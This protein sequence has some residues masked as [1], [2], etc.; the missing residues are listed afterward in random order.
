M[1]LLKA[2]AQLSLLL[3]TFLLPWQP[4]YSQAAFPQPNWDRALAVESAQSINSDHVLKSLYQSARAGDSRQVL[5][6]LFAIEQNDKWPVPARE[7]TIWS[8]AINLADLD[9]NTVSLEVLD[10]LSAY[11]PRTLVAHDDRDSV[12]VPLF[13][14]SSAGAGVRN[15]WAR[16]QSGGRAEI[17]L[18][19]DPVLWINAYLAAGPA[20]RRGF[21]D[22]LDF[23]SDAQLDAL[24]RSVLERLADHPGL[25]AIA[26]KSALILGDRD[27]LQHTLAL[28]SGPDLHHILKAASISL[29]ADQ[30][31]ALLFQAIRQGP[32]KKAGLAIAQLAPALLDDLAVRE[33]MFE[34]LKS[35]ELG[36]SAALVLGSS[37][38][39]EIRDRL[40]TLA[41]GKEGLA[42]QRAS[43]AIGTDEQGME[44]RR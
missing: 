11:E 14:I 33:K 10:Y 27:L 17:L 9:V 25:T 2:A 41:S 39:P 36:S 1:P 4:V 3:F 6:T 32:D 43:L 38:N 24:A 26:G 19:N 28:G 44:A 42:S 29:D 16:K 37:T 40:N 22:A 13:N 20:E 8:F 34:M 23:A 18:Q 5:D 35:R 31:K 12:G 30:N 15:S 7:Y 21:T